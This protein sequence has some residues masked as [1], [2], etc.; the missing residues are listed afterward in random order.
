MT[1]KKISRIAIYTLGAAAF[2]W[3]CLPIFEYLLPHALEISIAFLWMLGGLFVL[4][5]AV[6]FATWAF[7]PERTSTLEAE[8]EVK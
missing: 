5:Y 8:E 4:F 3:L 1:P 6:I 2:L 7:S